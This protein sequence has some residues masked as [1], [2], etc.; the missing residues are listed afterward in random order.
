MALVRTSK[1]TLTYSRI[2]K[3][4]TVHDFLSEYKLAVEQYVNYMW[5]N[6]I[7]YPSKD[8]NNLEVTRIFN[9]ETNQLDCPSMLDYNLIHFP[10][11]LSARALS[12]AATQA[13]GMVRAATEKRRK[14][15]YVLGELKKDN[16]PLQSLQEKIDKFPLVVPTFPENF[17]AELSSKCCEFIESSDTTFHGWLKLKCLGEFPTKFMPIR[18]TK[19]SN[20]YRNYG[21]ELLGS[22]LIYENNVDFRWEKEVALKTTGD[23]VG[24]D[25]G[26][27]DLLSFS[28]NMKAPEHP[29][30]HTYNDIL[31]RIERK[32]KDSKSIKRAYAFR[33]NYVNW[34]FNKLDFSGIKKLEI[35]DNGYLH[36]KNN[37]GRKLSHNAWSV[38]KEKAQSLAELGVLVKLIHCPYRS[39]RCSI[40][41]WVQKKNRKA[42]VFSCLNCGYGDDADHNSAVNQT[43]ELPRITQEFIKKRYNLE[44]FFWLTEGVFFRK[45]QEKPGV[46]DHLEKH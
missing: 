27:L 5:N 36:Y 44:G 41:G 10:T 9:R 7:S 29:H 45:S 25:P 32:T 20:K 3:K 43:V 26:I 18:W 14:Q 8:K 13:C 6:T 11:K 24:C 30:K 23:S 4:T 21:F 2:G 17:K 39:Q 16:K 37:C 15:L 1:H 42:K 31:N 19:H 35:E 46:P 38:I 34:Y 22:F 28:N 33:K 40:C 12:S